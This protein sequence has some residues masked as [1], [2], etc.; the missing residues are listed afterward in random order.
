MNKKISYLIRMNL[1]EVT[2]MKMLRDKKIT[3]KEYAEFTQ[4]QLNY[5]KEL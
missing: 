3:P 2:L 5:L 4:Q 1:E